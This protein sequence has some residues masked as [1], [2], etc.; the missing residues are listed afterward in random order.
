[1]PQQEPALAEPKFQAPRHSKSLTDQW[2]LNKQLDHLIP[3]FRRFGIELHMLWRCSEKELWELFCHAGL[4]KVECLTV[5]DCVVLDR[6]WRGHLLDNNLFVELNKLVEEESEQTENLLACNDVKTEVNKACDQYLESCKNVVEKIRRETLDLVER[7]RAG[8]EERAEMLRD[9]RT[10]ARK[11]LYNEPRVLT[12]DAEITVTQILERVRPGLR[13]RRF[14]IKPI[15][16][17]KQP[18][19]EMLQRCL[20]RKLSRDLDKCERWDENKFDNE[21]RLEKGG[22][23][24]V[25]INKD[26]ISDVMGIVG[27]KKGVHTWF[28]RVDGKEFEGKSGV[29][30]IVLGLRVN[31]SGESKKYGWCTR[32]NAPSYLQTCRAIGVEDTYA[33]PGETV[34]I[35]VNIEENILTF[36]LPRYGPLP[37][38]T[39][40]LQLA[41]GASIYPWAQL[42][43][44][45]YDNAVTISAYI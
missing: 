8:S 1:M 26:R 3:V 45:S 29:H 28:M 7:I 4:T 19:F 44:K 30:F 15:Y 12:R 25:K 37:F 2:L 38:L 31:N 17:Y 6:R 32:T 35:T 43:N 36:S 13:V 16:T 22:A 39:V 24:A 34:E 9:A 21:I 33:L 18:Q 42:Y 10:T 23:K 20:K 27:H 41:A 11:H 40:K 14:S 5:R